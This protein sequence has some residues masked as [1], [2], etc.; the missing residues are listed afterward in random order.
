MKMKEAIIKKKEKN[1]KKYIYICRSF[2]II[3]DDGWSGIV[4][5]SAPVKLYM[6]KPIQYNN[7]NYLWRKVLV[8]Y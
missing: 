7:K 1:K 8:K 2:S 3:Y 4:C 5:K 6:K